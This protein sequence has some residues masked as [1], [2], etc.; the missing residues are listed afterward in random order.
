VHRF[1]DVEV[2]KT[3]L[4][5]QGPALLEALAVLDGLPDE[6]LDPTS[7]DGVHTIIEVLKLAFAD[8]EAWYGEGSPVTVAELLDP[9]YVHA[10][11][12]L[13]G[14]L[15]TYDLRPGSPGT[16]EPRLPAHL[17][18]R[19][20]AREGAGLGEPTVQWG[21][22][23]HI[24]VADRWG[25]IISATPS[26]GWLQS[27]PTIPELGFCLGTRLQMCWLDEGLPAT[28]T[29]G[30][31]PRTTL[32]PTLVLRGGLPVLACGTPGGDQQEQWQLP[33]LLH[34]LVR[35]LDLQRAIEAPAFHTTSF[36]S[37]F[38]PRG[39]EPG[40]LVAEARLGAEVLSELERRGHRVVRAGAWTLGR[41]C[42]VARDDTG[43]SGAATS[44]GGSC[45]AVGR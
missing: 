12:A 18:D 3:D 42:A 24:D 10:R 31:R 17:T 2:A 39:T 44:R 15:A 29:P 30:R 21:D 38:Y 43:L 36:P 27:S 6:A 25:N 16:R 28:L 8:R 33:F 32:S 7:P 13:L 5:G 22:T 11:R 26:G 35:G 19:L 34:H 1:R 9:A 41:L 20:V 14:D 4:W 40:E 23:C 37:S 45:Y